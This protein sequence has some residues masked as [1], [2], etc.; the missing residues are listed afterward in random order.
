MVCANSST[1]TT[2][3]HTNTHS[4]SNITVITIAVYRCH[5]S[6]NDSYHF[7][8]HFSRFDT[9]YSAF[10]EFCRYIFLFAISSVRCCCCC[11]YLL[12]VCVCLVSN[13]LLKLAVPCRDA[14]HTHTKK[15]PILHYICHHVSSTS[16]FVNRSLAFLWVF[17]TYFHLFIY[18]ICVIF[19]FTFV[20]CCLLS[21]VFVVVL[22]SVCVHFLH[23]QIQS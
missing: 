16:G 13:A 20:S 23:I 6:H 11:C 3:K 12:S 18:F 1:K 2:D 14:T 7:A 19:L 22:E 9:V 15:Q 5:S 21:S 10:L 17:V 4:C 8:S